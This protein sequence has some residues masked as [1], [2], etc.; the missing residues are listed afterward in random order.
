MSDLSSIL[1]FILLSGRYI[2]KPSIVELINCEISMT[3]PLNSSGPESSCWT[4]DSWICH[5]VGPHIHTSASSDTESSSWL[6]YTYIK[7][8]L[9]L[10]CQ[11]VK[12]NRVEEVPKA[13]NRGWYATEPRGVWERGKTQKNFTFVHGSHMTP[14]H[15]Q[16]DFFRIF[17]TSSSL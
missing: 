14:S 8:Y 2:N 7:I 16:L 6:K 3:G 15:S 11:W 13:L 9:A 12:F 5:V 17:L 1:D 10:F 4:E